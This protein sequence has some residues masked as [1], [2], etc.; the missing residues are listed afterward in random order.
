MQAA[1]PASAL[2]IRVVTPG[3]DRVS[4]VPT[5]LQQSQARQHL[6][7]PADGFCILFVGNDYRKKGL[8]TLLQALSKLPADAYVAVVGNPAQMSYFK[9]ETRALGLASRVY[10]LGALHDVAPAYMAAN[11]LAH[12][13]REDTFAMV[14]LEAMA[15]G[16]PVVVSAERYCGIAA[17]LTPDV[18]ALLLSDPL[19]ALALAAALS[20]VAQDHVLRRQLSQAALAF[21]AHHQW[22]ALAQQQE[23]IYLSLAPD[24]RLEGAVQA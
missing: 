8:P 14:V 2:A 24:R 4:G 21:A 12:P 15:R 1:Y 18:N 20:R 10:F 9:A 19:D 7:L 5:P 23:Q 22:A 3:I 11:V 13:T 16:L 17:L 6:G